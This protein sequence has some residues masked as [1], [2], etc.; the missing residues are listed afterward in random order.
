MPDD[1]WPGEQG[2]ERRGPSAGFLVAQ[3]VL[4]AVAIL[5]FLWLVN[6][7]Q[8]HG[9]DPVVE[10]LA[11]AL[12]RN[13]WIGICLAI[14]GVSI[15]IEVL[16]LR[17]GMREAVLDVE[18]WTPQARPQQWEDDLIEAPAQPQHM[19]GCP[20]CGTVFDAQEHKTDLEGRFACPNCNRVGRLR[21]E[22]PVAA[23][24]LE[25]D[26]P[27]CSHHYQAYQHESECPNCGQPIR[28]RSA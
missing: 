23:D 9:R 20:G 21:R 11:G 15:V 27:S 16:L 17:P 24:L 19:I 28:I 22:T 14:L 12:S 18:A 3:V 2:P 25:V 26:C 6:I 4:A 7:L 8:E 5:V 13:A 10:G 1:P